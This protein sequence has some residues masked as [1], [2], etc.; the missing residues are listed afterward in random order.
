M[1]NIVFDL[2]RVLLDY[3]PLVWLKKKNYTH[4]NEL[5]EIIFQNPSWIKL[6]EG[7]ITREEFIEKLI[8]ENPELALD[9]EEIM[10]EWIELLL[11]IENNIK[12]VSLLKEKGYH[13]YIIS[14]FHL[15]ADECL[16][17]DDSLDNINACKNVGMDAIH[18]PDHSK[19]E[20]ELKKHH[21]I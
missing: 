5:F 8:N 16:F 21:I 10:E 2:G 1:K 17:I 6:D 7:T 13:L 15:N 14:N 3:Q 20:E 11:P 19:L 18:L 9:I 4:Y 12:L